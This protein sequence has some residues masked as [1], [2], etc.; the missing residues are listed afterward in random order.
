M[1]THLDYAKR[2]ALYTSAM[3]QNEF[4]HLIG[5]QI[6]K[7]LVARIKP[8]EPL[9]RVRGGEA[10]GGGGGVA[11]MR[12]MAEDVCPELAVLDASARDRRQAVS[13]SI[14]TSIRDAQM[15]VREDPA[16][17]LATQRSFD[18][19]LQSLEEA[20]AEIWAMEEYS[21]KQKLQAHANWFGAQAS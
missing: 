14:A 18:A 4:L 11:Q 8:S 19:L 20:A 16:D 1:R 2:N 12:P 6:L 9:L 10:R 7:K 3:I 21:T 15:A 5:G 17:V 13:S